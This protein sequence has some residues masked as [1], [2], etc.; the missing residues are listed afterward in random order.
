MRRH[1][2][3]PP[4]SGNLTYAV[5]TQLN[6]LSYLRSP[7][8]GVSGPQTSA[9]ISQF[10][11]VSG[12]PVDGCAVAATSG[13]AAGDAQACPPSRHFTRI[14][15]SIGHDAVQRRIDWRAPPNQLNRAF[16]E[17]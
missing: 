1:L 10:E 3:P 15:L 16:I 4:P 12:L 11:S 13:Q 5:Q 7:P 6:C 8:D 2:L 17:R 14:G 9:A